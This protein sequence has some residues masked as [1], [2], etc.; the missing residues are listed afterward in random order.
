MI[1]KTFYLLFTLL[2]SIHSFAQNTIKFNE[3]VKDFGNISEGMMA[4]NEFEFK[5]EGKTPIIIANV[6]AS[7]GCTTPTYTQDPV[8]PGATGRIT[9]VFNSQGRPGAFNKSITVT[10]NAEPATITLYLKGTVIPGN[11]P[12]ASVSKI[13]ILARTLELGPI[14]LGQKTVKT[15]VF[16]NTGDAPL[17]ILNVYSACNCISYK[18]LSPG[19]ENGI[20][21][22]L[23][24]TVNPT[25]M[26]PFTEIVSIYSDDKQ[27]PETKLVIRAEVID[28]NTSI[29]KEKPKS[30]F[31]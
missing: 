9:A 27:Q 22:T 18:N 29:M 6:Q 7:C 12:V 1:L 14:A 4:T 19:L 21:G 8:M 13:Q 28:G 3:E 25:K 10:S 23:Q 11:A 2:F 16:K 30:P 5:N 31:N 26:G 24:F 17:N 15:L 20:N